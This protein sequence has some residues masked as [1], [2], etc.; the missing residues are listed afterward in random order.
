LKVATFVHQNHLAELERYRKLWKQGAIPKAKVAEVQQKANESN[1]TLIR[2][3]GSTRDAEKLLQGQRK[4][5]E[6]LKQQKN[7]STVATSFA[8]AEGQPTSSSARRRI[9][10]F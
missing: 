1:N 4:T 2:A 7:S 3:K 9:D 8:R 6:N 10:P 5:Y